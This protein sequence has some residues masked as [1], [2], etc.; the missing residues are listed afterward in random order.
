[1]LYFTIAAIHLALFGMVGIAYMNYVSGAFLDPTWQPIIG[2]L[3]FL[4]IISFAGAILLL[5]RKT[6]LVAIA[7]LPIWALVFGFLALS[8][9]NPPFHITLEGWLGRVYPMILGY[10]LLAALPAALAALLL[11]W[12]K[13]I[14]A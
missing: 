10:S 12:R 3:I 9:F 4:V 2:T 8:L 14:R 7:A 1:M 6:V 5:F 13:S 11:R